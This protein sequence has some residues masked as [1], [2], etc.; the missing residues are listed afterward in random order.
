MNDDEKI[1][2]SVGS[3]DISID[4]KRIIE[5]QRQELF[6]AIRHIHKYCG[7]NII[8][9]NYEDNESI[10]FIINKL[11]EFYENKYEKK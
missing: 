2:M 5:D 10:N 3:G 7:I 4:K 9:K 1:S 6:E 8:L 11:H